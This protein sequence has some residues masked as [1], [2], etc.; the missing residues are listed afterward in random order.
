MLCSAKLVLVGIEKYVSQKTGKEYVRMA[1]A[2]GADTIAFLNDDMGMLNAPLYK[3]YN[4]QLSYNSRYNRLDL[5]SCK[6][7]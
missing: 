1:F 4:C 7:V 2:Q 3:E 5:M 6:T